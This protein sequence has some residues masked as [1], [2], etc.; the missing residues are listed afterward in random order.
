MHAFELFELE[1][2]GKLVIH[3]STGCI[4]ISTARP[5]LPKRWWRPALRFADTGCMKF[6]EKGPRHVPRARGWVGSLPP[7]DAASARR[8]RAKGVAR[9]R[10]ST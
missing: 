3:R 9:G 5:P 7:R 8:S 2:S 1:P 10:N 6:A 4:P